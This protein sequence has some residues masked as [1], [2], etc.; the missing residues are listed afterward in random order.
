MV[1]SVVS[2][3]HPADGPDGRGDGTVMGEAAFIRAAAPRRPDSVA[4][5]AR[6]LDVSRS[7]LLYKHIPELGDGRWPAI[8]PMR[9]ARGT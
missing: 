1:R 5:I 2:G 8:Q 6:L 9:P 3:H 4:S 7:T